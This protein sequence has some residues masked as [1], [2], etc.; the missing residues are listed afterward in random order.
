[1][2]RVIERKEVAIG[3]TEIWSTQI[4]VVR[5]IDIDKKEEEHVSKAKNYTAR[6]FAPIDNDCGGSGGSLVHATARPY[7]GRSARGGRYRGSSGA[8]R[9]SGDERSRGATVQV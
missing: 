2:R 4:S 1:L 9:S 5:K 3:K 8:G 7:H 6:V